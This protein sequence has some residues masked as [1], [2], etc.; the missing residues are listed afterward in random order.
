M[1]GARIGICR[2]KRK[3]KP[4][5]GEVGKVAIFILRRSSPLHVVQLRL[6]TV[7]GVA[8]WL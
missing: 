7:H 4:R 5:R 8:M 3:E 2:V 6:V 1:E